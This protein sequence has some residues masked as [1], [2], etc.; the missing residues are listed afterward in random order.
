VPAQ[1]ASVYHYAYVRNQRTHCQLCFEAQ[2]T[3]AR[4]I[5]AFSGAGA[6]AP[7]GWPA[8]VEDMATIHARAA[9]LQQEVRTIGLFLRPR[10]LMCVFVCVCVL[11]CD[12]SGCVTA[13]MCAYRYVCLFVSVCVSVFVEMHVC[14]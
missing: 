8:G 14:M 9:S 6:T 5:V 3:A 4:N 7:G 10:A 1:P 12:V 2:A 13:C 11:C